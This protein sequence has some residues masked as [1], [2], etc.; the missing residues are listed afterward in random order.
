MVGHLGGQPDLHPGDGG[1][2]CGTQRHNYGH[3]IRL[4]FLPSTH[5][6]YFIC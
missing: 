2:D 4:Q 1:A 3:A 5:S 6:S